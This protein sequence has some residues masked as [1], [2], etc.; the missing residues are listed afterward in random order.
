LK[1]DWKIVLETLS[2]KNPSR[3]RAG[4]IAQGIGPEFKLQY[5]KKKK[6]KKKKGISGLRMQLSGRALA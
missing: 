2:G 4:G 3:K 1:P 5:C 6:K